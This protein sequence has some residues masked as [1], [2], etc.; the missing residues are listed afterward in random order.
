[1][2]FGIN[3]LNSMDGNNGIGHYLFKENGIAWSGSHLKDVKVFEELICVQRNFEIQS[4][5]NINDIDKL[6]IDLCTLHMK[7]V[8]SPI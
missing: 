6:Y 8:H 3:Q 5:N 1:M 7:Q 2:T 4:K